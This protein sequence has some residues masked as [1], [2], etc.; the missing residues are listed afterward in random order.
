M[1]PALTGPATPPA[2][3]AP[4]RQ[5]EGVLLAMPVL[6]LLCA[7]A[8]LFVWMAPRGFDLTDESYY[9]L[10]YL[11]WRE[12]T[13]T[14]TFFGA[15]F[16]APFRLLGQHVGAVRVFGMA[17]LL[18]AGG[19]FAWR[20][21]AFDGDRDHRG[22]RPLPFVVGGMVASQFYYS[23]VTTLRAPS[24]NLLV[25]F[26][27]LVATGLLLALVEGRGSRAQ[28]WGAAFAY[29]LVLGACAFGKATSAAA[30]LLC[31]GAFFVAFN[32]RRRL[33]EVVGPALAGVALNIVLMQLLQ[34]NW[35]QVLRDGVTLT[36]TLDGRY[37]SIPFGT[38]WSAVLRGGARL[39]PA[40]LGAALVFGFIVRRWGRSQRALLSALV[41]LL[42]AGIMLT[43]QLQGYGKSWWVLLLFGTGL[44]WFTERLC[45]ERTLPARAALPTLGLTVLLF[46]L[47]VAY[48]IGTNGS[49]PSHTQMAAVFAVVAMMLP[50]RRLWALGLIHR[51][52]LVAALAALCVP[53]LVS[54]LRSLDD[55]SFTYRLRT[56]LLQQQWPV[57][58][59]A[60]GDTLR[61]DA[62]TRSHLEALAAAM[63]DAGY[64]AGEPILDVTGDA[65]GLVYALGGRP[66]G[67][68]WLIGGYAG[69]ERVAALVLSSV[70]AETLRHAWVLSADGN[71]RA[72]KTWATLLRERTGGTAHA[73][74]GRV[75]HLAQYRWDGAPPEPV[76][77]S[78]WKP[79]TR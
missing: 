53:T 29:G 17:M 41:V 32:R 65:P 22:P 40:L 31:H 61:V 73:L 23:Y 55:P 10:N 28:R 3:A 58:L 18:A 45:R 38:L 13:A 9:L 43:I 72:L 50:L 54:Q 57:A 4:A 78:L 35:L 75:P 52:A 71:P 74:A 11:H 27:M 42:V 48:S 76:M 24:Y 5:R 67:V 25:L 68:A 62:A 8:G 36:T 47:P 15:Y 14:A 44:L 64:T 16:E 59:G 33:L 37:A 12:V 2:V 30:M 63:R 49:L 20:V 60:A 51:S 56:G 6:A 77:L 66:V 34:P 39:L 7:Q 69:S 79:V 26:C 19:F 70:P 1:S 21:L 46:A